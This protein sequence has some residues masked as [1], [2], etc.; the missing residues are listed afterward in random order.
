MDSPSILSENDDVVRIMSVHKSKGLEFP[1]VILAGTSRPFNKND[2]QNKVIFNQDLGIGF[3]IVNTRKRIYYNSVPKLAIKIQN[4]REMLAEEMR[5]L[6]VALTR[7][8][9]KIIITSLVSNLDNKMSSYSSGIT[10]YKISTASSFSDWICPVVLSTKNKWNIFSWKYN[11]VLNIKFEDKKTENKNIDLEENINVKSD[12]LEF[13]KQRFLWE[14]PYKLLTKVSSKLSVSE[15]KRLNNFDDYSEIKKINE[16]KLLDFIENKEITGSSYGTLLHNKMER[17]DFLRPDINELVKDVEDIKIR[18]KLSKDI[19]GFLG[20]KIY[21]DISKAKKIYKETPFNLE[22]SIKKIFKVENDIQDDNI[23]VQGI[24]DLYIETDEGIIL[25]D[26]KSDKITSEKE[27]IE[28]Y[29]VQ[30]EYYKEAIEK[31]TK[32]FVKHTYIYSFEM[33]KI[34]ECFT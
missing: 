2:L 7:A 9:E 27:F 5:I 31:M 15:L 26:Y 28:K 24:I 1:I 6:Y 18:E 23:M 22:V 8:K 4:E 12:D 20:C 11:D 21:E 13:I 16:I 3:D 10:K 34:I 29:K 17:L 30:L 25:L 19:Q 33:G 14:Y 32:K